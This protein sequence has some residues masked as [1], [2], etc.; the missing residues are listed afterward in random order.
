METTIELLYAATGSESCLNKCRIQNL[1]C[2]HK[3]SKTILHSWSNNYEWKAEI[4]KH[5]LPQLNIK[6]E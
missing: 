3:V 6:L 4:E 5:Y 2:L 1:C